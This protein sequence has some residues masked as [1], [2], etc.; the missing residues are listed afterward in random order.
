[1]NRE[2]LSQKAIESKL[3]NLGNNWKIHNNHLFREF[4]FTNFVK[5]FS[6]M[7]EVAFHS[8]TMDHHPTLINTYNR[9]SIELWTHDTGGLT[10]LDFELAMKISNI[11]NLNV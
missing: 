2:L 4:K 6:F 3:E 1:M 7:T 8:E 9:V 5:A 11:S 10:E